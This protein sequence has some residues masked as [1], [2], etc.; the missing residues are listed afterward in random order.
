MPRRRRR[1]PQYAFRLSDDLIRR[2]DT[3]AARLQQSLPV[4][5]VTRSMA[6]R[7]LL[8]EAVAELDSRMRGSGG[9]RAPTSPTPSGPT[10]REAAR[11]RGPAG[12]PRGAAGPLPA[13]DGADA[14]AHP[15]S[16]RC[17][18]GLV[19]HALTRQ[20]IGHDPPPPPSPARPPRRQMQ[21][22]RLD[23]R[24]FRAAVYGGRGTDTQLEA[25]V[26]RQAEAARASVVALRTATTETKNLALEAM[27]AALESHTDPIL[28]ANRADLEAAE[29]A[30]TTGALL[31]RLALDPDRVVA[32]A[33][34]L[35]DVARL[36]DLV[37]QLEDEQIRPNGLRVAR[38][39][40]PLGLVAMIARRGRG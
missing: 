16:Y 35:R 24:W 2:I 14:G 28:E 17:P 11:P 22:R 39:R 27:A 23:R 18:P 36:P 5:R 34:G 19:G 33:A 7:T 38:M 9:A 10:S 37:G 26:R 8:A 21:R 31:D 30:G 25:S 1:T 6:L 20:G 4:V 32:M 13:G 12:H 40:V 29:A 15:Q 3:Y